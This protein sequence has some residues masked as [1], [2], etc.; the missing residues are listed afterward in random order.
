MQHS[1]SYDK[2]KVV[3]ALRLHFIAK[4]EIKWMMIT[5]NV[6]AIVSAVL[7]YSRKIRP[8]PF[9]LGSFVWIMMMLSVWYILPLSVYKKSAT[10]KDKFTIFFYE[11][12]VKLDNGIGYI[13]WKWEKFSNYIESVNFFYLY[14]NDKT[15]FLVPKDGMNETQ[16]HALREMFNNKK[17]P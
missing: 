17:A 10:F 3:H 14:F 8:E 11:E 16:I 2:K 13:F 7:F 12:E 15:F 5:V 6:F 1:F 4:Q 9:L